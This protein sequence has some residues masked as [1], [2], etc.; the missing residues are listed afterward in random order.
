[1]LY[2]SIKALLILIFAI[3]LFSTPKQALANIPDVTGHVYYANPD[4]SRTT[5]GVANIWVKWTDSEQPE[6]FPNNS[7]RYA[8]TDINGK[9]VFE[10]LVDYTQNATGENGTDA[11]RPEY[12]RQRRTWIKPDQPEVAPVEGGDHS[13]EGYVRMYGNNEEASFGCTKNP[14]IFTVIQPKNWHGRFVDA[15]VSD[16]RGHVVNASTLG[17]FDLNNGTHQ[18]AAINS[19]DFYY[20]PSII[21]GQVVDETSRPVSGVTVDI[22]NAQTP[23]QSN[24]AIT[25]AEGKYQLAEFIGKDEIYAVRIDNPPS[26]FA[27]KT[28]TE[29]YSW[30]F[31]NPTKLDPGNSN[32]PLNSP[33]Y[34][35]QKYGEDD[36]AGPAL[37]GSQVGKYGRCN[38]KLVPAPIAS[39]NPFS[40][41]SPNPNAS[42]KPGGSANP[43][44]SSRPNGSAF[45][46]GSSNPDGSANPNASNQPTAECLS[47]PIIGAVTNV[48]I[49]SKALAL[50]SATSL[51]LELKGFSGQSNFIFPVVI[52]Y[53]NGACRTSSLNF[54][55]NPASISRPTPKPEDCAKPTNRPDDCSCTSDSQCQGRKCD[56]NRGNIC[57]TLPFIQTQGGDVHSN[58][59]I[60]Q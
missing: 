24:P 19:G 46:D 15:S 36:C 34:E 60:N 20:L 32:T 56:P 30:R 5:R 43:N 17:G 26:G 13:A 12:D 42:D 40:S 18:D 27:P 47:L 54:K 11:W 53:S 1:M 14:Q 25:D 44:S 21:A 33:S 45:P 55:Y 9:F 59:Q 4:G 28:T 41:A 2:K 57:S 6:K 22:H 8:K 58:V 23:Q 35:L 16:P 38:F 48:S 39:S 10:I 31:I 7:D 3:T 37:A 49:N 51:L 29:L 52:N 50:S